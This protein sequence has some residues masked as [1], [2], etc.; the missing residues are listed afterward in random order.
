MWPAMAHH[1][2]MTGQLPMAQ[3]VPMVQR[4]P[5]PQHVPM[6]AH[7]PNGQGMVGIKGTQPSCF[8]RAP[9]LTSSTLLLNEKAPGPAVPHQPLLTAEH[10]H[11]F[12]TTAYDSVMYTGSCDA[13]T[14]CVEKEK[15]AVCEQH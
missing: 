4:A 8:L 1:G 5:M 12:S 9:F 6:G 14:V 13:I 7:M 2:P 11:D 3:H 10:M 15:K